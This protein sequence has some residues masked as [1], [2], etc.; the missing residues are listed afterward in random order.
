MDLGGRLSRTH[1]PEGLDVTDVVLDFLMGGGWGPARAGAGLELGVLAVSRVTGTEN[2]LRD[3]R[4]GNAAFVSLDAFR[5]MGAM[6]VVEVRG[7][8][9]GGPDWRAQASVGVRLQP[10]RPR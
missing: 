3:L 1:T 5:A 7:S 2:A 9:L 8:D 10:K 4:I 6:L